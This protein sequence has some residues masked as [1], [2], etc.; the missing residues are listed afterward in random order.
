MPRISLTFATSSATAKPA[1]AAKP[2]SNHLG[3]KRMSG[4]VGVRYGESTA[5][6]PTA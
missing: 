6:V 2:F 4:G 1:P 3:R 5:P